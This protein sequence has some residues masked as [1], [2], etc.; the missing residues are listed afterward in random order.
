MKEKLEN[1]GGADEKRR[2]E[3]P[4]SFVFLGKTVKQRVELKCKVIDPK[5][6]I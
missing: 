2:G 3:N 6:Y 1:G 4:T 5:T